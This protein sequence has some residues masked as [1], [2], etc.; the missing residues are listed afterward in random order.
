MDNA[1]AM[2]DR[3]NAGV[4]SVDRELKV[5]HWNLFMAS[6]SGKPAEQVLGR[7]L[8]ACFPELP[9]AW[10]RWKLRS[11][12]L[13]GTFAFS[14]WK[15]R[16][17]VFKFPHNRPLTG[18]IDFMH[19]DIAF[20]PVTTGGNVGGGVE[21]VCVLITDAT[22]AALSHRALSDARSRLEREMAERQRVE[23]ELRLA[24]K[25]EAVGQLAAGI[26]HEINTPIQYVSD[27]VAFIGEAFAEMRIIVQTFRQALCDR[28][29]QPAL[30]DN[31]DLTYL[32]QNVP[33]AVERALSGLERV[34]TLVRAMKE[35]GQP[36][37]G[38]KSF[39]DLNRAVITTLTVAS[40]EYK[41]VAEI[42]LELGDVPEVSCHIAELN[43]VF[44]QLILNATHAIAEAHAPP[45]RG[46]IRL[47]TWGDDESV[48]ISV[49]DN[50][51]G[52]PADIQPRIYDP[53]FTTKPIGKGT[54]QGLAIAHSI[55][56]DRHAGSIS[57]ETIPGQGTTFLVRLPR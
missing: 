21:S 37:D 38:T 3:L 52:I 12:F 14:S 44:L 41:D 56:V 26:A 47:R 11:V 57:F 18:G 43:Q 55:V 4:F 46:V 35:F 48:F 23:A 25:L 31:E 34:A 10:L 36:S 54:G 17:Y 51:C 29:H 5:T 13:L 45:E 40:S 2:L 8:F 39:A 53:F 28:T 15:Q 20:L 30:T 49:A 32:E 24:Q 27:S 42:Q 50:G 9:E 1:L 33:T 22:D 7:D 16:P 19:Q 6:N